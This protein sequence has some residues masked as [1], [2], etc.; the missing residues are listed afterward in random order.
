MP[1]AFS[2]TASQQ[3]MCCTALPRHRCAAACNR[4][5][6]S[7]PKHCASARR[8]PPGLPPL[9]LAAHLLSCTRCIKM[10][11]VHDVAE[12]MVG[13]ITPH[14]GVSD[15]DKHAMEAQAVSRIQAMLG[16]STR[17]GA[18]TCAAAGHGA[19]RPPVFAVCSSPAL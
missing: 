16:P 15:A 17:A 12:S 11:L 6:G 10:S 1:L 7:R 4:P 8:P 5:T 14:C 13:D 3:C 9:L 19:E 2:P 18:Y